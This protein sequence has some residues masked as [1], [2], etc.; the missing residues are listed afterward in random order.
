M[1]Y[2]FALG[3]EGENE[4][5]AENLQSSFLDPSQHPQNNYR[6]VYKTPP[7]KTS[8]P[9]PRRLLCLLKRKGSEKEN[10]FQIFYSFLFTQL[11]KNVILKLKNCGWNNKLN[12]SRFHA[13]SLKQS[14]ASVGG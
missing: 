5:R 6:V 14:T 8:S 12:L 10:S 7:I 2:I 13:L 4:E 3:F 1:K 9:A 11:N